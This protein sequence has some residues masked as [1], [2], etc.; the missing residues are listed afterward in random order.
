M[1]LESEDTVLVGGIF[2]VSCVCDAEDSDVGLMEIRSANP[3]YSK[4]L[5]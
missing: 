1:G 2:M 5:F 4:V 3:L